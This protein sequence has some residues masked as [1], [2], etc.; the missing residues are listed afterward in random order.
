MRPRR[1][2]PYLAL[3]GRY[4]PNCQRQPQQTSVSKSRLQLYTLAA[5]AFLYVGS[6]AADFCSLH[7]ARKQ[8]TKIEGRQLGDLSFQAPPLLLRNAMS[9]PSMLST[10]FAVDA[11]ALSRLKKNEGHAT[12]CGAS[13]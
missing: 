11:S 5:E 10:L 1:R 7:T 3:V 12:V 8:S 6:C 9:V 2:C 13:T 4:R